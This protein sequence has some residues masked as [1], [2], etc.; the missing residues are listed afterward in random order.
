MKQSPSR[1]SSSQN[2]QRAAPDYCFILP[3]DLFERR[4]LVRALI[5]MSPSFEYTLGCEDEVFIRCEL[6]GERFMEIR[7]PKALQLLQAIT[8][9]NDIRLCE[10]DLLILQ[11][12]LF[13]YGSFTPW[14]PD[15][16][17][18]KN[19]TELEG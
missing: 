4:R 19:T 6:A 13:V 14:Y 1:C 10:N 8:D 3:H 11:H 9:I 2:N 15:L 17:W 7:T 18:L 16:T 5:E 12:N